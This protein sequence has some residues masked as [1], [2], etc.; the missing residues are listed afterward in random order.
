MTWRPAAPCAP[1]RTPALLNYSWSWSEGTAPLV[2]LLPSEVPAP[3]GPRTPP[4]LAGLW[5]ALSPLRPLGLT[6]GHDPVAVGP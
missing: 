1:E 4:G 3:E 5:S 2:L 6:S